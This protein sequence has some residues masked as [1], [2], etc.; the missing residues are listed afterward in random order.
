MGELQL[1]TWVSQFNYT[2]YFADN[3]PR[4]QAAKYPAN[5]APNA[6]QIGFPLPEV[7][8]AR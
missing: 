6:V 4:E 1:L 2:A 5:N 7:R 3:D 8:I